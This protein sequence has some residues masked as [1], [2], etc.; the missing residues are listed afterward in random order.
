MELCNKTL[1]IN[2]VIGFHFF[3][4]LHLPLWIHAGAFHKHCKFGNGTIILS[5]CKN[6]DTGHPKKD[7]IE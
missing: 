6:Q 4:Q 2:Q 3:N 1:A 7:Y 5:F